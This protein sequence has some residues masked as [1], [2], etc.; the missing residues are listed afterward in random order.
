MTYWLYNAIASEDPDREPQL[1]LQSTIN[2]ARSLAFEIVQQHGENEKK[3][4]ESCLEHFRGNTQGGGSSLSNQ[5]VFEPL[6]STLTNTLSVVSSAAGGPSEP[7]PWA[8]PGVIVSW[9]YAF[10]T[11][12]RSMLAASGVN[13]PDTHTGVIKS[14][15]AS[16]RTKMPHPLNMLARWSRN[17]DFTKELPDYPR[18]GSRELTTAFLP[19]RIC[20]Q[21]MLLGYLSGTRAREVDKVK[22]RLRKEHGYQ[23]FRTKAARKVR[24]AAIQTR[25]YNFMDCAFRYR[26]K[27]NYRDA[28]Y[29][30]YG[31]RELVHRA[32]F[33]ASLATTSK[34]A[35]V[36]A[37]AFVRNR[38]GETAP[39]E[40][41]NDLSQ[42]LRGVDVARPEELFWRDLLS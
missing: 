2:W 29:I 11:A 18:V 26:G 42:N 23:D 39:K 3:Q 20:A 13:A 1:A 28:I 9:Y 5:S 30:S 24:D 7:R 19:T 35:F 25:V 12:M 34:F 31:S 38:L 17:E 41:L 22:D 15:G 36:C 32:E 40:F 10:Y 8:V 4:Y 14:V 16:L 33:L 37:L 21:E 6:F 27:A